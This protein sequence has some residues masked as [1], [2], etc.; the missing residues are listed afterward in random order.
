MP[1]ARHGAAEAPR[2]RA[3]GLAPVAASLVVAALVSATACGGALGDGV[4]GA[5]GAA[6]APAS[7]GGGAG[8]GTGAAGGVVD[9]GGAGG[10]ACTPAAPSADPIVLEPL[11]CFASGWA[12]SGE[13][14][15]PF[16]QPSVD[17][18][19][20]D[21]VYRSAPALPPS[22]RYVV[23]DGSVPALPPIPLAS[24]R[25]DEF[26]G[27][28]LGDPVTDFQRG[29]V[30][31]YGR[32]G[33]EVRGLSVGLWLN[34]QDDPIALYNGSGAL[35]SGCW[36]Q[37]SPYVRAFP[38]DAHELD[39][40]FDVGVARDTST[41]N[42]HAQ[43]YF[44]LIAVDTSGGCGEHCAFSYSVALY[45]P[46]AADATRRGVIG[47]AT[48]TLGAMPLAGSG[49]EATGWL[50][51]MG[52]SIGFHA[53]PFAPGHVH[54]RIGAA[55][56]LAVRD[57]VAAFAPSFQGLSKSALD[58]RLSLLNV[59]GEVYDPCKD[60]SHIAPCLGGE[61]A[62]IG[63]SVKDFRVTHTVPHEAAGAPWA[64]DAAGERVVFR[65]TA[66]AVAMFEEIAGTS[67]HRL[68][69]LAPTGSA[70]GA[71]SGVVLPGGGGDALDRLVVFFRDASGAIQRVDY[72]GGAFSAHAVASGA[73]SDPEALVD[74]SG[75]ARFVA[76]G[77]SGAVIGLGPEAEAAFGGVAEGAR[78]MA[79]VVGGVIRI[80]ARDASGHV[81]VGALPTGAPPARVDAS[82]AAKL[83]AE[84]AAASDPR[85]FVDPAGALG[86]VFR[87]ADGVIHLLE[88]RGTSFSHATIE[89]VPAAVG[90]PRPVVS[91]C[92]VAIAYLG[93]DGHAHL[94]ASKAGAFEH[95]DLATVRGV[96]A[97]TD[98]PVPFATADRGVRVVFRGDDGAL[99]EVVRG[100]TWIARDF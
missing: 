20:I 29:H 30:D 13:L 55:E 62:Q 93:A 17:A 5:G 98:D 31:V 12:P 15:L 6:G 57:A 40:A 75:A 81:L 61:H 28:A 79:L 95:V 96:R 72:A 36:L 87:S 39:V 65:S 47:D 74:P 56:L 46:S 19:T 2:P 14:S 49:I 22:N 63:L 50:H 90:A 11:G 64:G 48:G 69:S 45:S 77:A 53:A 33:V 86:V 80:V 42:A 83:G 35:T 32:T 89:G 7:G 68:T 58:Y 51:A 16:Q 3:R 52:D 99:H 18:T 21:E 84:A 26:T 37:A 27:L 4:A 66:G 54:F 82:A 24:Y 76:R 91:G 1:R 44:Q 9:A 43:V 41:G 78:P 34:T 23:Y 59:N 92:D 70:A 10:H 8:H 88:E 94:L 60:P 100:S 73:A 25:L 67:G 85:A 38:S 97:A 71:P